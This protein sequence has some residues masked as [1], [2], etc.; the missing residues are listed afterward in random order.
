MSDSNPQ[1]QPAG[2]AEETPESKP[3]RRT[4]KIG[5][6]RDEPSAPRP[7][8]QAKAQPLEKGPGVADS[9]AHERPPQKVPPPRRRDTLD[10]EDQLELA[11]ALGDVNLDELL[12]ET[13]Q[14]AGPIIEQSLEPDAKLQGTV[15]ALRSDVAVVE[16]GGRDQG[17]VSLR[18][19][20]DPPEVGQKI[21]VIVQ[22]YKPSEGLYELLLPRSA[23]AVSDWSQVAEGM[24][25][26][27]FIT[28]ENKGGLE[29]Q[30]NQLRGFIPASHVSL[31]RVDDLSQFVGQKLACLV[32]EADPEKRNLVL[33]HRAVLEREQEEARARLLNELA[34]GQIREGTVRRLQP[35]GAFVDLGG[36][37]DGLLHVSQMSWDRIDHPSEVLAEGQKIKVKVEKVDRQAGKISLAYRDTWENPWERAAQKYAVK[38]IVEGTV[39]KLTD[40]GAFVKL[41][42]GI[43]GLIHVSELA[44]RHVRRP[45]E[46]VH[47]GQP[48]RVQVVSVDPDAQ[49]IGLSLKALEAAPR[50]ERDRAAEADTEEPFMPRTK[51]EQLKGGLDRPS[52]G[53]SVGLQW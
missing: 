16:L 10:V 2:P 50:S 47:E 51:S 32:T 34:P 13:G 36:G 27:A 28:G 22:D 43:E 21:E 53:D 4:I 38:S 37:V 7:K 45:A 39:S 30:I 48:V 35:F 44:H 26:E 24:L 20:P 17:I 9:A 52:G 46:V 15:V 8:P 33:S 11:A 31:W 12:G 23:V 1:G 5:S 3:P 6:Q 29:C 18:Q 49:R 40:F 25:V 14:A 19:F 41:E 42:P